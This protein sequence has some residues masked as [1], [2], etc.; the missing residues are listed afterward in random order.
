M[1]ILAEAGRRSTASPWRVIAPHAGLMYSG[2]VAAHAYRQL[3]GRDIDVAVL[4]GPSHFVGFEGVALYERGAFETPFG[5]VAIDED[6]AAAVAARS[7]LVVPHPAAHAREHSLEMQLPFLRRVLPDVRIVPLVMG[8][9][10]RETA[11]ALADAIAGA[12]D[13]RRAVLIASTDLSHYQSA[14]TAAKLDARVIDR[15]R[16]FDAEGLMSLLEA[17]P[18]HA[19]GGGPTVS[20]MRAAQLAGRDRGAS[21]EIRRLGRCL[22]RQGCGGRLSRGRVGHVSRHLQTPMPPLDND[23]RTALLH[24]ARLAIARAVGA[25][26]HANPQSPIFNPQ[27]PIPTPQSPI[28]SPQSLV[29]GYARA[30][31]FV[32]LRI[33]GD[34]RGCI[35]YPH[36]E[37]PLV[38]VVQRC[39]VSAAIADPRFPAL[40]AAEFG[41]VSLEI[42]V[43]GPLEPVGDIS[44]V[45]AGRHGL[46]V[47]HEGRRGLLLPQ[48]A[49]EWGWDAEEFASQ[50]CVKAGLPRDAWRN[51]AQ[52][53]KFEA[54]VF[55]ESP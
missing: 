45:T 10:R 49:T 41:D 1:T 44:E 4:V 19:C 6:C 15:V 24:L 43:L 31:A 36:A 16:G 32:T 28:P 40:Q 8:F 5:P 29:Q 35:G 42:S 3:A 34:L 48:V 11:F 50:T 55:G 30:G 23:A 17:F 38:E 21:A 53:Y 47:E 27:S 2:P 20:V 22:R 37:L 18:E 46:V 54:E 13:R 9:Q 51:G 7:R 33:G 25:D 52:L 26:F 14:A 39:A 12:I